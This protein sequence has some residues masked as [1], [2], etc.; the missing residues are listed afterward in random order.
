MCT[1]VYF[2]FTIPGYPNETLSRSIQ[3]RTIDG[4]DDETSI[5]DLDSKPLTKVV[6]GV[7]P[8]D[9]NQPYE[10]LF[11]TSQETLNEIN[12]V[13]RA[14]EIGEA[15]DLESLAELD[16]RWNKARRM[17]EGRAVPELAAQSKKEWQLRRRQTSIEFREQAAKHWEEEQATWD[18]QHAEWEKKS[19]KLRDEWIPMDPTE[20]S[21]DDSTLDIIYEEDAESSGDE[22][23]LDQTKRVGK[24]PVDQDVDRKSTDEDEARQEAEKSL[25]LVEEAE[26]EKTDV[27][28][29]NEKT[30]ESLLQSEQEHLVKSGEQGTKK[31]GKTYENCMVDD[32]VI[33]GEKLNAKS[34]RQQLSASIND[35]LDTTT[36]SIDLS[37]ETGTA[38]DE[39]LFRSAKSDLW[40]ETLKSPALVLSVM[41]GLGLIGIGIYYGTQLAGSHSNRAD[42][43]HDDIVG[44]A[45]SPA[46]MLHERCQ[47]MNDLANKADGIAQDAL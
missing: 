33:E 32:H 19:Q 31:Q 8:A 22:R 38:T 1:G 26:R 2:P 7:I 13:I 10:Q 28:K 40:Y 11:K 23:E 25:R 21:E 3:K 43:N 39:A 4:L 27:S 20:Y 18:A 44:H 29:D 37:P 12:V 46:A 45:V 42:P 35:L 5:Q 24:E 30:E 47:K 14:K 16:S 34:V 6:D 15:F 9:P 41:V 17:A 36:S